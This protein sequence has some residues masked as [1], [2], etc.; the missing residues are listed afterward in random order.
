MA[1]ILL[2][3]FLL[4][5]KYFYIEMIAAASKRIVEKWVTPVSVPIFASEFPI[6]PYP[7]HGFQTPPD[8]NK[9]LLVRLIV[10]LSQLFLMCI[11]YP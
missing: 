2:D 9:D 8:V 7:A 4:I 6:V 5:S 10:R 3:E 11:F 1:S